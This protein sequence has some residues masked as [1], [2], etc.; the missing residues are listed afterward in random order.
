[1]SITVVHRTTALVTGTKNGTERVMATSTWKGGQGYTD[2]DLYT[3]MAK[4]G[5]YTTG[6]FGRGG[7]LTVIVTD[8]DLGAES[9]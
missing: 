8:I 9:R 4:G 2:S 6:G 3:K 7:I 1:M 5:L